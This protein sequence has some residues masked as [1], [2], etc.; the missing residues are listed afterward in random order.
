M[1]TLQDWLDFC[2]RLHPV[3]IDMGLERVRQVA[4]AASARALML[5]QASVIKRPVIEWPSG[6]VTVGFTPERWPA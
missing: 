6:A 4:D 5:Q 1:K 3:T 2:E